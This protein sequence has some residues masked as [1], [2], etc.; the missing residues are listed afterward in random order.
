MPQENQNPAPAQTPPSN[1]AA[2]A[3]N[4]NAGAPQ[5]PTLT[6][7]HLNFLNSLQT[8]FRAPQGQNQNPVDQRRERI[9]NLTQDV[10]QAVVSNL[11]KGGSGLPLT[12]RMAYEFGETTE[13]LLTENQEL[14]Q[15]V[16]ELKRQTELARDPNY[17]GIV[18]IQDN[19]ELMISDAV[20]ALYGQIDS[21][22]PKA[23]LATQMKN[24]QKESFH[25]LVSDHLNTL[26]Q[27]NDVQSL[28]ALQKPS[29]LRTLIAEIGETVLPPKARDVLKAEALANRPPDPQALYNEMR[30]A[31][32]KAKE[33]KTDQERR[34]W[35][36]IATRA[37]R[38][39]L[40]TRL[41]SKSRR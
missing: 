23:G 27:K 7:E 10:D 6:Q 31:N 2:N 39:F 41:G 21:T 9:K 24:H 34:Q 25:A 26:I 40:G 1:P 36:D 15:Q 32:Q 17:R 16:Q 38:R 13:L 33:A 19:A 28:K 5:G 11:Q 3:P 22:D 37:R 14:K 18:A 20:D 4:T 12:S 8:A 29:N 30:E 35:E